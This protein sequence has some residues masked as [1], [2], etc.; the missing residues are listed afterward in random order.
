MNLAKISAN[1]QITVPAEIRRLLGLKSGDKILFFQ[2]P[3]GEVVINNASAQAI[4]KAQ[5]AFAGVAEEI[6]VNDE[7]DVQDLVNEVRYGKEE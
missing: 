4:Y 7:N 5:E 1:G 6:G 2:K 3:N